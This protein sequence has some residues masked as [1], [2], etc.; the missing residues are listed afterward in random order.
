MTE[1]QLCPLSPRA[2]QLV[3]RGPVPGY[4]T[5]QMGK[6]LTVKKCPHESSDGHLSSLLHRKYRTVFVFHYLTEPG[7]ECQ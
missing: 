4:N 3:P 7:D 2:I 1:R 6:L 5:P